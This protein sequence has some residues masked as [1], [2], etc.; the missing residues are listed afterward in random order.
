MRWRQ[1]EHVS[2]VGPTGGGKTTLAV[3]LLPMR[4]HVAVLA[5]KPRDPLLT[6]A[7]LRRIRSWPP[8]ANLD[9]V[10]LWPRTPTGRRARRTGAVGTATAV[11]VEQAKALDDIYARGGWCLFLDEAQ[12][13]VGWCGLANQMR[14]L[15]LHGRTLGVSLV[16]GAQRPVHLPAE[17]WS[18]ATHLF[19]AAIRDA[20]DLQRI[21]EISGIDRKLIVARMAE[22]RPYEFLYA[23]RSGWAALVTAPKR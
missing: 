1:G 17:A 16:V 19:A 6:G 12:F 7:G 8:P 2:V 23:H 9:R 5:S 11:C 14:L 18:Q 15:W 4:E 21:G 10:I 13:T 22:L 20:R 3:A